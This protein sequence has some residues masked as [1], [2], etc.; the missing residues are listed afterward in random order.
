MRVMRRSKGLTVRAIAGSHTVLLGF[1][2]TDATGCMGFAVHRTDHNADEAYW[3]RGMKV[4]RSIIPAPAQGADYSLRMHPVQGFQWADYTAKPGHRYTYRVVSLKGPPNKLVIRQSVSLDVTTEVDD[5]GRHGIWFNRGAAASQA[6]TKRYARDFP[7]DTEDSESYDWLA[8]GLNRAFLEVVARA[9]GPGWSLHGAF[10]EF[11]WKRAALAFG[12]AAARGAEVKLV[13]HGRDKDKPGANDEDHTAADARRTVADAAIDAL[14]TWRTAE[15]TSALQHNKF[16]VLSRDGV[17]QAVWTGST[18]LTVG[19]V[20][21]HSNVGHLITSVAVASVFLDYWN[22]LHDNTVTSKRLRVWTGASNPI[23][24]SVVP[25]VPVASVASVFSPRADLSVL[26]WYGRLVDSATSSAHITGAFGLNKVFFPALQ[27]DRPIIR[28]VL[29][30]KP[31]SGTSKPIPMTDP[32]VRVATGAAFTTPLA[33]WAAEKLTGFNGHVP[34]IHT[35]I[36][37]ID[38]LTARP[39]VLTGSANYSDNST[40]TNEENTVIIVGDTRVADIYLTEYYRIFIHLAARNFRQN[41]A[42]D[43]AP[44]WTFLAED[45]SWAG[46]YFAADSWRGHLRQLVAGT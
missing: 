22:Q 12:E 1:D 24:T 16:L 5:D 27:R 39:T 11:T 23:D 20:Y 10:Y 33:Q 35:K 41:P 37:L 30:D 45:D 19:G 2:L 26:E 14:V 21:G 29:L 6:F 3:L 9:T 18:N 4:F 46:E 31:P 28:N 38:P 17:P 36:I 8:R 15:A 43:P 7:T 40:D 25:V 13:I 44:M 32:D 34:Y 42:P